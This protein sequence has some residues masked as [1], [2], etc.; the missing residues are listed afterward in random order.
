MCLPNSYAHAF[1]FG[2]V[3]HFVLA[4]GFAKLWAGGSAWIKPG[5]MRRYLDVYRPSSTA[6]PGIPKLNAW[7]AQRDWATASL[8]VGTIVIEVIIIPLTL[9]MPPE[10]RVLALW[11]MI[12]LHIGIAVL[13]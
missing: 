8:G 3:V 13:L 9:L 12:A 1:A 2:V 11:G 4:S 6:N 10:E 7:F 5:T